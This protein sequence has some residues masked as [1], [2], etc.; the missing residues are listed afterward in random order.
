MSLTTQTVHV[1]EITDHSWLRR[2]GSWLAVA[3]A[4]CASVVFLTSTVLTGRDQIA[5]LAPSSEVSTFV[6]EHGSI[7]AIDHRAEALARSSVLPE[8]ITAL[9]HQAE[10]GE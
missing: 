1:P 6:A 2:N 5:D 7:A 4:A 9:D 3:V 8:S 10:S